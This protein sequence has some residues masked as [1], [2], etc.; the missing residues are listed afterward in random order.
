VLI[1]TWTSASL[2]VRIF[3]KMDVEKKGFLILSDFERVFTVETAKRAFQSFSITRSS[4]ISRVEMRQALRLFFRERDNLT[5]SLNNF[6]NLARVVKTLINFVFWVIMSLVVLLVMRFAVQELLLTFAT[7]LVSV[8]FALGTSIRNLVES[9]I[10][11]LVNKPYDVGDRVQIGDPTTDPMKQRVVSIS[12][13]STTFKSIHGK[14]MIMPNH[15]LSALPITNLKVSTSFAVS[16]RLSTLFRVHVAFG[17][18][19]C[20]S[21]L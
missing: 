5:R 19:T 12:L 21:M 2:Q 18:C 8:S 9:L 7:L 15:L 14:L 17:V 4:K 20:S 16:V 3:R 13:L 10:F 1:T 11:L 6:D